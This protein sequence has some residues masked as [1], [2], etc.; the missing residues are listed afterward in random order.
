[1]KRL[2]IA[3]SLLLSLN[4]LTLGIRWLIS[5]QVLPLATVWLTALV[6]IGIVAL[7]YFS[8]LAASPLYALYH[9]E[10]KVYAAA[11][12]AGVILGLL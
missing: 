7:T 12:L 1:M 4:L 2:A 8:T 5:S 11:G 3:L 10:A 9:R 6:C